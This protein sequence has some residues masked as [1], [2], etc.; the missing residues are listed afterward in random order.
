MSY[1]ILQFFYKPVTLSPSFSWLPL[2]FVSIHREIEKSHRRQVAVVPKVFGDRLPAAFRLS[3]W[4]HG[5]RCSRRGLRL[6]DRSV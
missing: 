4:R 2:Q 5:V 1:P 6:L 3:L